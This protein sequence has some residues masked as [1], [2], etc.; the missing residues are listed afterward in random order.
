MG[1]S[2]SL[3]ARLTHPSDSLYEFAFEQYDRPFKVPLKTHHGEWSNRQG[4]FVYLRNSFGSVG[5]GEI[6]PLPWFGTESV[7]AAIAFCLSLPQ[8][9]TTS[10]ILEIPDDFPTVQFG[11]GTAL[12]VFNPST[13]LERLPSHQICALLPSGEKALTEWPDLWAQGHRT[14]KWKMGAQGLEAELQIF[15]VLVSALPCTAKL[16]L[17]ANGGLDF[18]QAQRWAICCDTFRWGDETPVVEYIEQPL[19]AD[20]WKNLLTLS[21]QSQTAI[22]LDESVATVQD[23]VIWQERDWPGFYVIKPAIMGFPQ[24][25]R[26]ICRQIP[27]P[28]IFSSVFEAQVGRHKA[29]ALAKEL[30]TPGLALG[31]GVDHWLAESP[32]VSMSSSIFS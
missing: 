3:G 8:R 18:A 15:R 6:S 21:R 2:L 31:F 17:D 22:A 14:F 7:E 25:L 26:D 28:K 11:L 5:V 16:R 13:C 10:D 4:I 23:L 32:N 1:G 27:N 9:L 29:L 30:G 24:T 19:P 12:E 20:D